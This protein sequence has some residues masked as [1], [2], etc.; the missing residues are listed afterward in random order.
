MATPTIAKVIPV[1]EPKSLPHNSH[2]EPSPDIKEIID[3]EH[4]P[5]NDDPRQWSYARKVRSRHHLMLLIGQ[6]DAVSPVDR[7]FVYCVHGYNGVLVSG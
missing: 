3:I 4:V 5:V 1:S 6:V 2:V 7:N